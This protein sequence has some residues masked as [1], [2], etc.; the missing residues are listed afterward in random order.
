M[1]QEDDAKEDMTVG[2]LSGVEFSSS[3]PWLPSKPVCAEGSAEGSFWQGSGLKQCFGLAIYIYSTEVGVLRAAVASHFA[4]LENLGD[5][6][7][8][9]SP[10]WTPIG[11]EWRDEFVK[12]LDLFR[13]TYQP[14]RVK[15]KIWKKLQMAER[16]RDVAEADKGVR[17]I[18][19]LFVKLGVRALEMVGVEGRFNV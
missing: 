19:R 10:K 16:T 13:R 7:F 9:R 3:L 14:C 12:R 6:L 18:R 4:T 17:V 1:E 11:R 5:D 8:S 2:Y 15:G